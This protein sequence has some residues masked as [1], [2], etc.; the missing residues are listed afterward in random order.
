MIEE[1]VL[2]QQGFILESDL[3][4][5]FPIYV[6]LSDDKK[7]LLF[8][9][10]INELLKDLRVK[11]QLQVSDEGISFLLQCGVV[12]PPNTAY[13]NIFILGF[14]DKLKVDTKK[15]LIFI[16]FNHKFPF[17]NFK[18]LGANEMEPNHE[19][20]LEMLAKAT[21]S[22]IDS[23]KPTFLFHSAGKDSNSI[24]LALSEAGWQDKVTLITHKSKGE[25]DESVLSANIAKKLG[26]KHEV[27]HEIG[28]LN[29][30]HKK[31]INEFFESTPFPCVD[32]VTLAYP[33]Y[34]CQ[35]PELR[36]ANIIDGGGNDSYMGTPLSLREEKIIPVLNY[37]HYASKLRSYVNSESIIMA[38]LKTPAECFGM[39]GMSFYDLNKICPNPVNSYSYWK[40]ES[41]KRKSWDQIDFKTDILTSIVASEVHIR[42]ARCFAD[43]VSSN[44]I[45]PFTNSSVASYFS[46]LPEKYLFDRS[47][48]SNKLILRTILKNRL[49]L[50]SDSIGKKGFSYDSREIIDKNWDYISQ[51][52]Y[53]CDYWVQP[54]V[55]KLIIRLRKVMSTNRKYSDFSGRL[56]YRIYL[57]SAWQNHSLY[58]TK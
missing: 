52:I 14:G 58:L 51:E 32:N 11:N 37:T 39:K 8:S 12:P 13:K 54:E 24:A 5:E 15:D 36:G 26:F 42:K 9:N 3:A 46:R 20:I 48:K 53:A 50:D 34:A 10:S 29:K 44:L 19:L 40:E 28:S 17:M 22:R 18:R 57:L 16:S 43:V 1:Y 33:L 56:I 35:V 41:A 30:V 38:A 27:L 21:I 6:F 25:A 47:S 55:A 23:S 49:E 4:G 2:G 7:I 31:S 45:L